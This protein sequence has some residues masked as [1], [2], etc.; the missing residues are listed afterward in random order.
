MTTDTLCVIMEHMIEYCLGFAFAPSHK[1]VVLIK[2]QR[3]A[4]QAGLLNGVGGK[5]ESQEN[6][7]S[8]M[9]REFEEETGVHHFN[10]KRFG[11]LYGQEWGVY[12]FTTVLSVDELASIEP[13]KTDE[14]I[15]LADSDNLSNTIPNL[16][17][18]V[19]MAKYCLQKKEYFSINEI[20][21]S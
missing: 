19:P 15:I 5:V 9:K 13:F 1:G 17:W 18:L 3:P 4:W 11:Y 21:L 20:S 7:Y 16:M 6:P 10:W 12:L 2:K 14:E 8:A